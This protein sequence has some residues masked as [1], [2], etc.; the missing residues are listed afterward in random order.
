M[1]FI[2]DLQSI[3]LKCLDS[4]HQSYLY[5]N[6]SFNSIKIKATAYWLNTFSLSKSLIDC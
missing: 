6:K 2:Y 1:D 3:S 5:K 4:C